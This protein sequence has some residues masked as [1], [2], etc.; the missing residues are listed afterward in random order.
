VP[1]VVSTDQFKVKYLRLF[2]NLIVHL[3]IFDSLVFSM[4]IPVAK[5][6]KARVCGRSLVGIAGS[7]PA[8]IWTSV[9]CECCLLS[10]RGLCDG[11]NPRPEESYRLWC[12]VVCDL[13]A[14]RNR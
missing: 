14:S 7:N 9:S 13:Q 12:V 8:V 1:Y 4:P 11:P 3:S 2:N 5:R 6:S 10:G